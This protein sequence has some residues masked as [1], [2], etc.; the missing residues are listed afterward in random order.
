MKRLSNPGRVCWSLAVFA[1]VAF[2][3]PQLALGVVPVVKT[4]PVDPANA[5]TAHT[6][7]PG[8][9]ITLKGTADQQGATIMYDWNFGDGSLHAIGVVTNMFNIQATHT[10]AGSNLQNFT[11]VL[12][13]TDTGT[14]DHASKNYLVQMVNPCNLAA[15]A[16]I[17]I[18]EGLWYLH[19][20][21]WRGTS[22]PTAGSVGAIPIGGWDT[23]TG[24][25]GNPAAC[26][27]GGAFLETALFTNTYAGC[28]NAQNAAVITANNVQA[29]EVNGHL[30]GGPASDPYKDDVARALARVFQFLRPEAVANVTITFVNPACPVPNCIFNP[31]SNGNGIGLVSDVDGVGHRIYEGGMVIDAI[32]ASGTGAATTMTGGTNVLGR[33]YKDIVTDMLDEFSYCQY[34]NF[35]GGAWVYGCQDGEDNSSAQWAAIGYIAGSRGF[36]IPIPPMVAASNGVWASHSQNANGSW[37]Y[38]GPG[39]V[40]G[41]F[42]DTPSGMVQM[43]MDKIGRG[44][45][46]WNPSEAFYRDNFCNNP[47]PTPGNYA[48]NAVSAPKA[49]TY[50]MFSFTKS[51]LLHDPGGVLTPIQNLQDSVNV[52]PPPPIDWYNAEASLGAP[53]D[54]VARSLV[55]R[56]GIDGGYPPTPAVPTNGW[57]TGHT[58]WGGQFPYETAW[59]IIMLRKAVFIACVNN[60]YGRGTPSGLAATRVDLTWTG[61]PS[62]D[63][64][65][66]L[67]G[68]VSGGPYVK[69]GSSTV[70][71]FRDQN[72]GL[73]NGSTYYYVLQPI[74]AAGSEICQS[75]EAKVIIPLPH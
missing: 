65:D 64:Y 63:H 24:S 27:N 23:S 59:S 36:G 11:A 33:S 18:D 17:A 4:V 10:Y 49:Y 61:I 35:P 68:T 5:A 54:G 15:R 44:D 42:A 69:V 72:S 7:C 28:D 41:F 60:L 40:W 8:T 45:A 26:A 75:N 14:G 43:S 9:L 30:E 29:F 38:R 47:N 1:A 73:V 2:A 25:P 50:G 56:Q 12:T 48:N 39:P 13:V 6:A 34:P 32:V 70:T 20:I 51:M 22:G 16:N 31:D 71:G 67:R 66:V 37:G 21:M 53:C 3:L 52:S 55:D 19:K 62:A 58:Y 74:N 46:R 57:W